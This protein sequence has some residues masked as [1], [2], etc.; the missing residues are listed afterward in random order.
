MQKKTEEKK[1]NLICLI[2]IPR[3]IVHVVKF[4][5]KRD[6]LIYLQERKKNV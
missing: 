1:Y 4:R 3:S 6:G 2:R 5:K